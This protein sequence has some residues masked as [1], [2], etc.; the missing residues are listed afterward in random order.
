[1]GGRKCENKKYGDTV[2]EKVRDMFLYSLKIN[3][4]KRARC[5]SV[6]RAKC[7]LLKLELFPTQLYRD[8]IPK[9]LSVFP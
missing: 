5:S 4:K 9:T 7:V 1:M 6:L 2:P 8:R 3:I